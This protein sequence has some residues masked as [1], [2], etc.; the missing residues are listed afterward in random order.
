MACHKT[1]LVIR[2]ALPQ[3]IS[4][5]NVCH[6]IKYGL[7]VDIIVTEIRAIKHEKNVF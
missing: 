4:L 1:W 2:Y 7:T 5:Y 3:N 6:T